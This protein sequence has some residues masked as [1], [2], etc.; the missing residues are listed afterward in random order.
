[1]CTHMH[2]CVCVCGGGVGEGQ[3]SSQVV[4]RQSK[5][6]QRVFWGCKVTP[7]PSKWM[8]NIHHVHIFHIKLSVTM[9]IY[10]SFLCTTVHGLNEK[11][12]LLKGLV[13]IYHV[14]HC[15]KSKSLSTMQDRTETLWKTIYYVYTGAWTI[16][17]IICICIHWGTNYSTYI[18]CCHKLT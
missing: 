17:T 4:L 12:W 1:V 9:Q 8:F 10:T 18:H 3:G 11:Y 7:H 14:A 15:N 16:W 13:H 6:R 2:V 5:E